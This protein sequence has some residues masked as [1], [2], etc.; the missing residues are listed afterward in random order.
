M[1]F[2]VIELYDP[3]GLDRLSHYASQPE[4]V[5]LPGFW[6]QQEIDDSPA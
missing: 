3:A 5:Q 2:D 4:P 6:T 1:I